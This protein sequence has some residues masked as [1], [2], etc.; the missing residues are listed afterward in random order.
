MKDLSWCRA[1]A[2]R[3]IEAKPATVPREEGEKAKRTVFHGG[4]MELSELA[5]AELVYRTL[6][7]LDFGYGGQLY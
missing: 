2:R 5:T 3:A 1:G 6:Q 7:T 4:I